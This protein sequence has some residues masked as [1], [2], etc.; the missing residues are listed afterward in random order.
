MAAIQDEARRGGEAGEDAEDTQDTEL[1]QALALSLESPGPPSR[2]GA[3]ADGAEGGAQTA[4][5]ESLQQALLQSMEQPGPLDE[6]AALAAALAA[7][8]QDAGPAVAAGYDDS[9]RER[10]ELDHALALSLSD[11]A[12]DPDAAA[13][14]AAN[15]NNNTAAAAATAAAG[16]ASSSGGAVESQSER[17]QRELR[18]ALEAA[19]A[20]DEAEALELASRLEREEREAE[21]RRRQQVRQQ[22][23]AD[24]ALVAEMFATDEAARARRDEERAAAALDEERAAP[25][26]LDALVALSLQREE[27]ESGGGR[28]EAE[29]RR[30]QE[31]ADHAFAAELIAKEESAAEG[32]AAGEEWDAQLAAS[33][34]EEQEE[35]RANQG[36]PREPQPGAD[37]R[38]ASASASAFGGG[39]GAAAG[40][41]GGGYEKWMVIIDGLNVGRA[42]GSVGWKSPLVPAAEISASGPLWKKPICGQAILQSVNDVM[43]KGHDVKVFLPQWD[44]SPMLE[45]TPSMA[46]DDHFFLEFATRYE[47]EGDYPVR[48]LSNDHFRKEVEQGNISAGWRDEHTIKYKFMHMPRSGLRLS[49]A[50]TLPG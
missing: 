18:E 19:E 5:D 50:P 11:P 28:E 10:Q 41:G 15:N 8:M 31:E 34:Q 27:D 22:E 2:F 6:D 38:S 47:A 9:E 7:S 42:H 35:P 43:A 14:A 21:E 32:E 23:E 49:T 40:G 4:E 20:A 44:G 12:A 33:L 39:G 45:L 26:D 29:R 37:T 48:V 46:S 17:E 3:L 16:A 30:A 36:V 13:A 24:Q 1:A 25:L